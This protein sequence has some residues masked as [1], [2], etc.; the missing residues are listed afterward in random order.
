M[1]LIPK[2]RLAIRRKH[3][4][5]KTEKTYVYWVKDF[6]KFNQLKHPQEMGVEE[7]REYLNHLAEKRFV[8]AS[9]Q[10]QAL[11]ALVFL[12]K[13]VLNKELGAFGRFLRAKREKHIPAVLTK[14]E[15]SQILIHLEGPARLVVALLYGTGMRLNECLKLRVKDLDFGRGQIHVHQAKGAKDRLVP[16]PPSLEKALKQQLEKAKG[17]HQQDLKAG[18][19][20]VELPYALEKKYR[21][22]SREWKWQFVFPSSSRCIHPRKG[23]TCRYH[24][25]DSAIAKPLK[26]VVK[27]LALRKKVSSH[28]FRHSF[29]THQLE[30]GYDIRVVQELLGH[31]SIKTTGIY[32]HIANKH[33]KATAS[34]LERLSFEPSVVQEREEVPAVASPVPEE[35][36]YVEPPRTLLQWILKW[37]RGEPAA[38]DSNLRS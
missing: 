4:S 11:N 37:I 31:K 27:R 21:G 16:L 2:L 3:Y 33:T 7:I 38:R 8:A 29:A 23:N 20:E 24:L 22:A 13:H 26:K 25:H 35:Q 9:T 34:P 19:G 5:Y 18:F 12:Y 6:I 28:T 32:L 36:S 15:V 14:D 10:N 17:L 1:K 30:D